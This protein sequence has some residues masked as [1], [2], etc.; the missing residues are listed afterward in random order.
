MASIAGFELSALSG[1]QKTAIGLANINFD[2]S[3]VK[4]EAPVEFQGLGN[5]L[6]KTRKSEAESGL[7]HATAR[8][9]GSLFA[10]ILPKSPNLIK[11]Y[12]IRA[13]E[14]AKNSALN[15]T[16]SGAAGP[17]GDLLG[18]DGTS[19]WAAATSGTEAIQV[20]MLACLL[21]RVWKAPQAVAIWTELVKTRKAEIQ[22]IIDSGEFKVAQLTAC[23][24]EI[25]H[26]KLAQWDASARSVCKSLSSI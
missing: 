4:L 3:L 26:D 20:H 5:A 23:T 18:A 11:A 13:S 12:G 19:I 24:M 22:R 16:D 9:L 6:S 2:F 14:I 21:A 17:L 7:I 10:D 8:K 1:S 15:L 25:S